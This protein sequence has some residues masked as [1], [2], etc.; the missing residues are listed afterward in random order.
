MKGRRI[1][2][3]VSVRMGMFLHV[4]VLGGE[5]AGGG[6]QLVELGVDAAVVPVDQLS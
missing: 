2:R 6:D 3:P 5:A 1:S 4:G